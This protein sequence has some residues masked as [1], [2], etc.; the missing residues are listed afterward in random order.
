[1][2][3]ECNQYMGESNSIEGCLVATVTWDTNRRRMRNLL[4]YVRSEIHLK[5]HMY[6]QEPR[7]C[8][9]L[10]EHLREGIDRQPKRR[11]R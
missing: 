9:I 7:W 8:N 3:V 10:M 1:M 6:S 5:V 4:I 11:R 2:D